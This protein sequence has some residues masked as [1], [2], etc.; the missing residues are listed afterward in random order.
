MTAGVVTVKLMNK[1][2]ITRLTINKKKANKRQCDNLK[3][4]YYILMPKF[5]DKCAS[6]GATNN[7][8]D[9]DTEYLA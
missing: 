6:S 5:S 7:E 4:M 9:L 1:I 8:K 2:G 3:K